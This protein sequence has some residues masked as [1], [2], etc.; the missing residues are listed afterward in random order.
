MAD[1][2]T[3]A[4]ESF[5]SK[6]LAH[7]EAQKVPW[8]ALPDVDGFY[9]SGT[10]GSVAIRSRDGD[11]RLPFVLDIAGPD[12]GVVDSLETDWY[13]VENDE[14]ERPMSWNAILERL[15]H[16]ARRTALGLDELTASLLGDIESG[17]S[18]E[19]D[20]VPLITPGGHVR[21]AQTHAGAPS[22]TDTSV[23]DLPF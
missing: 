23:D 11:G 22:S 6:L 9:F 19:A 17:R 21:R 3:E 8:R 13:S 20:H 1:P 14:F 7:T 5:A 10:A 15:Y 4:L 16:L 12:N 18:G 2:A